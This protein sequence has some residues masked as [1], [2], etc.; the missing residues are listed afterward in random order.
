M[1]SILLK[2]A[3][4]IA[5]LILS[6]SVIAA[7]T[8]CHSSDFQCFKRK[9]MPEVG[10]KITVVGVLA[11]AKLGWI[12][13]F[14]SWGVYIYAVENADTTKMN[15]LDPFNG[16]TVKVTATLRYSPGSPSP[17]IDV[18]SVPEH[19][20]FDVAKA[21]VISTRPPAEIMFREMHLGK[22]PLVELYFDVVLRNDRSE[23]RWF[24]LP[25]NLDPESAA[26]GAK[27]GVDG[28]EVFAPHG[29]GRVIMGHF[30]GTGGFNA[31]LLPARAQVRLRMFPMSYWGELPEYLQIG[32]VTAK[33]LTIGGESAESWFGANAMS[34]ARADIAES[35]LNP[36]R[37]LR[38]KHAPDNKEVPTTIEEDRRFEV[39]VRLGARNP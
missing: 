24:L 29:T 13:T 22:P 35:S 12:V 14:E 19:F 23:P 30:L 28:V 3:S 7:S 16:Q 32:L 33:H 2:T 25:S 37:V 10:H 20:F 1:R 8:T 4:T 36:R 17:R 5:A 39:R 38:A 18:A 27:G 26:I 11:S 6:T 34:R 21:K 15:G 31:L 9:M